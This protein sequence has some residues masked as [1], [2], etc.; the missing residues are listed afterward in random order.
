MYGGSFKAAINQAFD[1]YSWHTI[2]EAWSKRKM[3]ARLGACFCHK[4]CNLLNLQYTFVFKLCFEVN[5]FKMK[6]LM[7]ITVPY[8]FATSA[9]S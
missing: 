6:S 8:C 2:L 7:F 4:M 5:F 3:H 9:Y 1:F